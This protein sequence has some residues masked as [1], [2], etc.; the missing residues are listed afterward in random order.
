[1]LFHASMLFRS[2]TLFHTFTICRRLLSKNGIQEA[3]NLRSKLHLLGAGTLLPVALFAVGAVLLQ[4]QHERAAVERDTLGRARAAMS[5]IDAHLRGSIDSLETLGTSRNLQ[6]GDIRSF[7]EESQRVLRTQ[8]GWVNI[9]LI[10]ADR[11]QL[12][13]A[14]YAF[15]PP[16]PMAQVDMPSYE[17]AL[18]AG[19]PS[20]G[21][22][23]AGT[24]VRSPTVRVRVPVLY[25]GQVR[26]V[27]SAP[28]SLKHISDLL[29]AQKL[30]EDWGI[31]LVDREKHVI[32]RI[33]VVAASVPASDVFRR[34]IERAPEGWFSGRTR[35]GRQTYTAYVTSELSGWVLGVAI[36]ASAV[37]D[38]ARRS[39]TLLAAGIVVAAA[40][41]AL[42][43]WLISRG[44]PPA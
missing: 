37:N 5:A 38:G 18:R 23:A 6:T 27:L 15:S 31:G 11:M 29:S 10:S 13:N 1:M 43:A 4:V 19:K 36:P 7:H 8:P 20:I 17:E 22:I 42:F 26:Y 24:V 16:E 33:P 32:G 44:S 28:L 41:V 34:E 9:G 12:A 30:P 40:M 2:F 25:G 3:L 21:G 35:E 39:F 14:V